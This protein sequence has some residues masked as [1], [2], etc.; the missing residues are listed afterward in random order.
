MAAERDDVGLTK[1]EFATFVAGLDY[2]MFVVTAAADG[3]RAGCLVGFTTQAS[4]DPPR[5]LVCLSERNHTFE[6]AQRA[7]FLGVHVV[8]PG[9]HWLAEL[10][11]G[12]S[13]DEVDKFARCAWFSGPEGLPLLQECPRRLV[14]RV[15]ERHPLGDHVGFLLQPLSEHDGHPEQALTYQQVRDVEA[16]HPA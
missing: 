5:L 7:Q 4:I 9:Q 10:F 12:T 11:G 14:G 6:V 3:R 8:E 15:L 1:D 2:P 16:G 13:G